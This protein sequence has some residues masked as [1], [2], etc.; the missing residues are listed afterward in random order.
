MA[1]TEKRARPAGAPA[2][3]HHF[4]QGVDMKALTAICLIVWAVMA[5]S[6]PG[7][8]ADRVVID[9][10]H[11][12][13]HPVKQVFQEMNVTLYKVEL[14]QNRTYPVF[15]VKFPYDPHL[16]HNDKYFRTLY[17]KTLKAN[18]YW[19]YAFVAPEDRVRVRV[20][21]DRAAKTMREQVEDF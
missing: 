14:L 16:G 7:A 4:T 1:A 6:A 2:A 10:V 5:L 15:H 3:L 18:G 21:Y 11:A 8:A 20:T 12:W 13:Q 9:N 19:S 17:Q